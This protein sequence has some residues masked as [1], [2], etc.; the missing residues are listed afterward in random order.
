M[1]EW[2]VMASIYALQIYLVAGAVFA[3]VFLR[4]PLERMDPAARGASL[5]FRLLI[6]P[7]VMALW[8]WLWLRFRR[9]SRTSASAQ[10]AVR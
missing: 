7:G 5:G 1:F 9:L 4:S 8:P 6:A 10:E 2:L 3:A